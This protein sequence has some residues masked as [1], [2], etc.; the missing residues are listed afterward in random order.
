MFEKE[1]TKQNVYHGSNKIK[2]LPSVLLCI[3]LHLVSESF[4]ILIAKI[5]KIPLPELPH[6]VAP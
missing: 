1:V 4:S 3:K 2:S 6:Q 5:A